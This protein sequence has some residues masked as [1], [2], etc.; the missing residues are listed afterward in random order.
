MRP[1]DRDPADVADLV[2]LFEADWTGQVPAM[3]CTRMVVSPVNARERILALIAGAQHTL[4]IES[5]Q[6]ADHGVRDA[7]K[8]RIAAGV[9]VRVLLADVNWIDAN[10]SAV[11]FLHDLGVT[12]KWIPHLH[13]KML[14]ADGAVAYVGSE[15]LSATSL[16]RNREVG[17]ILVEASSIAPLTTTF[18]SDWAIGTEF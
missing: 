4:E 7:V 3:P 13:T 8:A 5:M 17:V 16:D 15:N 10:A 14:V 18:E 12:V 11:T 9:Q 1:T 2:T 6:F